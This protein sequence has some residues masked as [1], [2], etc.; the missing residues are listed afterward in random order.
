[1]NNLP[2]IFCGIFFTLAFSWVGIVLVSQIQY[3]DLE[4]TTEQFDPATGGMVEDDP[5][6][7]QK[8]V[9][10]AV[11]GKRVYM[12]LGC[13]YCHTQQVRRKGYGSDYE[14]AW[15]K[16]QSVA[17]D[18]IHQKRVLLGTM[19]TGP[20][21]M[22][23]GQRLPIRSW[24]H[25]HL[26]NPSITS[27]GSIMPPYAFLYDKRAIKGSEITEN[28][29]K[30]PPEFAVEEGYEVVPGRRAEALVTYLMSLKLDYDLP[31]AKRE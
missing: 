13:I 29:L 18:Y 25:L 31:E 27:Q 6:Y 2:L 19:R 3:G 15:G 22:A 12:D 10:L 28:A 4:P 17:R 20:D 7:P 26:Y 8:P 9:G 14:R 21:L 23:V 5:L 16:R 30:L 11:Q 1:M 24:H